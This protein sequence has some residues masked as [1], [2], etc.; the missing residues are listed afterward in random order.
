MTGR[1]SRVAVTGLGS[2]CALGEGVGALLR[3][4]QAGTCGVVRLNGDL[5]GRMAAPVVGFD[6]E[7][8]F[9]RRGLLALDRAAQFALM[10]AREALAGHDLAGGDPE[11]RGVVLA[12]A[13]GQTTLDESYAALYGAGA[14]RLPPLTVPRGMPSAAASHVAMAFGLTGPCFAVASACA[15][16]THAIG[17]AFQM[18][19]AG[20][21]DLAVCGGSDASLCRGFLVAWD[22]LRVMSPD[23]CRPFSRDRTGMVIGE[24][25]GIL[26]LER[27]E[28]A[29]AR[30]AVI[31]AELLGFGMGADAGDLIAPRAEGAARAMRACLRDA[32]LAPDAIDHVNAHGTG[33]RANDRTEAAALHAVFG[34]RARQVPVSATKS[35]HGH[36]LNGAGGIEAVATVLSL[37]E[38]FVP[39]TLGF[40]TADPDCDIDCV[41]NVSRVARI[42]TALSNSFAFGGLNAVLALRRAA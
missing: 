23:T 34:A 9:D 21:L 5:A 40:T 28:A 36:C 14:T 2:V 8:H 24:G 15:S 7:A 37:R 29:K 18:V 16:A 32:G 41:P 4:L 38:G 6:P 39:P 27:W 12:A 1:I 13:I 31:H 22:G 33:T 30:G 20:T 11:R 35:L 42:T 19:R 17:L 3:G 26:V 10:G 25:A